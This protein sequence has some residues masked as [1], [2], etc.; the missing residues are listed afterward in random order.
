MAAFCAAGRELVREEMLCVEADASEQ[1]S[2]SLSECYVGIKPFE[3]A[4]LDLFEGLERKPARTPHPPI[5]PPLSWDSMHPKLHPSGAGVPAARAGRKCWQLEA[6]CSIVEA[7]AERGDNKPCRIVDFAAGCGPLG[8]PLAA[9]LPWATI[10][11]LE[12][13]KRSLDIARARA[14]EAGLTNVRFH[15][16]DIAAYDEP[17]EIGVALHACGAAS[18]LVLQK[19]A[20]AKARYVVCPCCTGKL[21]TDRRDWYRFAATGDNETRVTYPRSQPF[22][23][24]LSAESYNFLACAADVSDAKLLEGQRGLLRRLAKLFLEHDRCLWLTEK[25]YVAR[26]TRMPHGVEASPKC[27]ILFGWPSDGAPSDAEVLERLSK[28]MDDE[29]F[30][31]AQ[32]LGVGG[33]AE[34]AAAPSDDTMGGAAPAR[35]LGG[36]LGASEWSAEELEEMTTRLK[37]IGE[38]AEDEVPAQ[39]ARLRRLVHYAAASLGLHHETLSSGR[40]VRVRRVLRGAKEE[41][42][43]VA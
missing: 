6:I 20:E 42:V 40:A 1:P 8:L 10:T 43:S 30:V 3:R 11:I 33:G 2:V 31:E 29:D 7:L 13:K 35:R 26:L 41:A 37:A 32:R 18:D 14:E 17:F 24:I 16:G 22:Q 27:D 28:S 34:A 9:L 21:S 12:L 19:C 4:L 5:P 39:T 25:G 36:A 38:D 23:A 15:E